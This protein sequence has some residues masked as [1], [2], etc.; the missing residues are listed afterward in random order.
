MGVKNVMMLGESL[1]IGRYI[2]TRQRRLRHSVE[3][4]CNSVKPQIVLIYATMM[5]KTMMMTTI[6]IITI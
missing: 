6:V 4:I 5:M 1:C 2:G 3:T